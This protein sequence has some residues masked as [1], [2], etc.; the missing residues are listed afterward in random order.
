MH[1]MIGKRTATDFIVVPPAVLRHRLEPAANRLFQFAH[2]AATD[3]AI[4]LT[5]CRERRCTAHRAA[6]LFPVIVQRLVRL[7]IGLVS[8]FITFPI[9][10]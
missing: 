5:G 4:R 3:L 8:Y 1:A 9:A 2:N 10:S 6:S 7:W